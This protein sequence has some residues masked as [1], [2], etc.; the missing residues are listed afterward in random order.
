MQKIV[1][2]LIAASAAVL[3]GMTMVVR[4]TRVH[5]RG[6][7]WTHVTVSQPAIDFTTAVSMYTVCTY[8]PV[9]RKQESI[10][11]K[12]HQNS[13]PCS[14]SRDIVVVVDVALS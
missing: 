13:S 7:V 3:R 2:W 12:Y 1:N 11:L 8:V 10:W 4:G 9:G 14:V 5:V 6:V